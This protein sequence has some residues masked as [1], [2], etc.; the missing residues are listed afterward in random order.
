[1]KYLYLIIAFLING[2]FADIKE[3]ND[4]GKVP[5]F[6]ETILPVDSSNQYY[7]ES[8]T[9][10]YQEPYVKEENAN[11]NSL[12]KPG[13]REF[14]RDRR[15]RN[16]GD[17]LK[18]KISIKNNAKLNN[19][20]S[21]DRTLQDSTAAPNVFGYEKFAKAILPKGFDLSHLT[22]ITGANKNIGE[23]T[24]DRKE[25]I[26]TE[27]A[28]MVIKILPNGSLVIQGSQ[29]VRVNYELREITLSGIIRPEDI[30]ADNSVGLDQIAEARVSY[31]GRGTLSRMQK[32]RYGNELIE[33]LS[34]F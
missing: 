24:I 25:D 2:C 5:S 26:Q 6:A 18:V 8:S 23:G 1:M 7:Q 13:S 22:N 19:S 14:F 28:A 31:G 21:R 4:I 33:V 12:W 17:I 3:L 11:H 27:I 16:I 9:K 10:N 34:P 15:V 32:A 30:G 29:E 20:T